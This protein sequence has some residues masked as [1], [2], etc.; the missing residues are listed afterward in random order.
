MLDSGPRRRDGPAGPVKGSRLPRNECV[1]GESWSESVP[2]DLR[3]RK[4]GETTPTCLPSAPPPDL[5][6]PPLSFLSLSSTPSTSPLA[7]FLSGADS[8][9]GSASQSTGGGGGDRGARQ[10][11][12]SGDD[13]ATASLSSPRPVPTPLPPPPRPLPPTARA[14]PPRLARRPVKDAALG[15]PAYTVALT[16]EGLAFRPVRRRRR[17]AGRVGSEAGG[18]GGGGGALPPVV[19][20]DGGGLAA[21]FC[22]GGRRPPTLSECRERSARGAHTHLALN[23]AGAIPFV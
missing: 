12:A 4:G 13:G 9:A 22:G 2:C 7:P 21:A 3:R 19:G 11:T 1:L 15:T 5:S 6:Q 8:D 17:R 23:A 14:N 10:T 20:G 18:G 16:D